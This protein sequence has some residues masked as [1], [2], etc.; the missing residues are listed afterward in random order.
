MQKRPSS[1]LL[2]MNDESVLLFRFK[3]KFGPLAGQVFWATPG[4]A[5][6]EGESFEAAARRELFEE[7][8]IHRNDVG[9]QIAQRTA[10]FRAPTGEMIEADERFFLIRADNDV[11]SDYNWTELEREV[12]GEHRWWNQTDLRT[13]AEQVWPEDIE[14]ML[15]D[16][17]EWMAEL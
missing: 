9:A 11:V 14:D 8:G 7:V 1:R 10:T 4:G 16:A 17:G 6:E 3:H 2:V 12:M 13:A 5:L 15:I